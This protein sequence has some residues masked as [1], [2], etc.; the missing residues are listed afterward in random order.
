MDRDVIPDAPGGQLAHDAR[1]IEPI[2]GVND[3]GADHVPHPAGLDRVPPILGAVGQPLRLPP[4][5]AGPAPP[6]L[7]VAT[8]RLVGTLRASAIGPSP[9]PPRGDDSDLELVQVYL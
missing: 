2:Q 1:A 8:G 3:A 7:A 4:A 5:P 6:A 9:I